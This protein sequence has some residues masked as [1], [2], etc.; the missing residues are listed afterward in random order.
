MSI[1]IIIEVVRRIQN[2][3]RHL[4]IFPKII[5]VMLS[6]I[7]LL[8]YLEYFFEKGHSPYFHS[9]WDGIW[10]A[11]ITSATVGYGD[12]YPVTPQGQ[13]I[14]IAMIVLGGSLLAV[15][16]ANIGG[17][18][19]LR[20][21]RKERGLL[22]AKHMKDHVVICH[23]NQQAKSAIIDYKKRHH[24]VK[25]VLIDGYIEENPMDRYNVHFI[26]GNFNED[27]T[28]MKANIEHAKTV[29]I[30]GD[31]R[32]D[33]NTADAKAMKAILAI[34]HLNPDAHVIVESLSGDIRSLKRVGADEVIDTGEI[35]GRLLVQSSTSIG[36]SEVIQ[37]LLAHETNNDFFETPVP[38]RYVGWPFG[39]LAQELR[40]RGV[41]LIAIRNDQT[42]LNP[43]YDMKVTDE[44]KL[45][46]ISEKQI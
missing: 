21:S 35:N 31:K 36:I 29:L 3:V 23:W 30:F 11:V 9:W 40:Q 19:A 14:A 24:G 46:Y 6:V 33:E 44:C 18:L 32:I 42:R 34:K 10:F 12:K 41:N 15:L 39:E 43:P 5:T 1:Y 26:R 28:L 20:I 17:T 4:I 38:R 2:T 16:L 13:A 27:E 45:I 25:F 8:G 7:L 37:E 22:S